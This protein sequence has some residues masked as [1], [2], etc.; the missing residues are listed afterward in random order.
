MVKK[1][2]GVL[3]WDVVEA[4]REALRDTETVLASSWMNGIHGH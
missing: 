4:V 1:D 2:S 3:V